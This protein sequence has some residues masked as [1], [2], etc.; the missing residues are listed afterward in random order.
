MERMAGAVV[1]AAGD[2]PVTVKTRL[3]WDDSTIRIQEVALMLQQTGVKALTVHARTRAQKYKGEARWE[4]LKLLKNTPGLEITVIGIGDV[5]STE[6]AKRKLD[7]TGW[8]G[9]MIG[10]GASSY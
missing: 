7:E 5:D 4:Y 10:R 2:L 9:V 1:D 8:T 6:A 3:G